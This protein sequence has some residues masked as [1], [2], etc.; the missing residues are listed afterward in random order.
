[1]RLVFEFESLGEYTTGSRKSVDETWLLLVSLSVLFIHDLN[2]QS[3]SHVHDN[4]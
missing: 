3:Q 1:M 4:V 2:K